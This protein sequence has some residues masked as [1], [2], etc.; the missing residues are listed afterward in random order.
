M[1]EAALGSNAKRVAELK[2]MLNSLSSREHEVIGLVAGGFSNKEIARQLDVTE[3]TIKLH[4]NRIFR[5][6]SVKNRTTLAALA[7]RVQQWQNRAGLGIPSV[8]HSHYKP[9]GPFTPGGDRQI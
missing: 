2:P 4:L 9:K 5:K 8:G 1:I 6:L 7:L 3:G